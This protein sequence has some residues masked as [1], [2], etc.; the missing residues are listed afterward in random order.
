MFEQAEPSPIYVQIADW[1]RK[2]ILSGEWPEHYR[3]KGEL[4][5]A[6]EMNVNRGTLR[7]AIHLLITEGLLE[8]I[9]GRG[10][11]VAAHILEENLAEKLTSLAESLARQGVPMETHLIDVAI[12][13]APV[14]AASLLSLGP[15]AQV[16]FMRRLRATGGIRFVYERNYVN[17]SACPGIEKID[18]S[19]NSLYLTLEKKYNLKLAWGRRTYH[20]QPA[21]EEVAHYLQIPAGSAVFYVQQI[22]Y[23]QD[24]IPIECSDIWMRGDRIRFTAI[25]S[26]TKRMTESEHGVIPTVQFPY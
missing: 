10:T 14:H 22:T 4:H 24:N 13:T 11:F 25:V 16:F 9:Q 3:L 2:N 7:K 12:Q 19:T 20:S 5:L 26:R 18:F 8:S 15:A 23:L 1:M 21:I 6:R 17:A